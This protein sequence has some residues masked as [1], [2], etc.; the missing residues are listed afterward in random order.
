MQRGAH[1][2][3]DVATRVKQKTHGGEG[4]KKNKAI[5]NGESN[6]E[7]YRIKSP[8]AVASFLMIRFS[9]NKIPSFI[10]RS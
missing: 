4:E 2:V 1:L 6:L 10:R 9:A 7:C 8:L 3:K 5:S